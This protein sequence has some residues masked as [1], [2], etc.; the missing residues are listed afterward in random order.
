MT[1]LLQKRQTAPSTQAHASASHPAFGLGFRPFFLSA[2]VFATL[3]IPVWLLVLAGT[4]RLPTQLWPSAWHAHEMV[5][6]FCVAVVAG[7][8]LTA[9]GNWTQQAVPTGASL[10]SMWLLWLAGRALVLFDGPVPRGLVAIVDLAFVPTLALAVGLPIV[11]SKN[12]RNLAFVPLLL[13][14]FVANAAFHF[15]SPMVAGR[16]IQFAIDVIVLI[17]IAIGGR[18]IPMFTAN[19]LRLPARDDRGVGTAG[20]FATAVVAL[21]QL[22]SGAERIAGV[23]AIVAGA[24]H[25]VRLSRWRTT[26]TRGLPIVWVLHA[27]YAWIAIGL[28]LQGLA[29][30]FPSWPRSAPTHALTVG[31]L[32]TLI[33]GMMSRVSLGHTGRM[34]A[35]ARPV[36]AAY[37]LL[38]LAALVRAVG[39][40]VLPRAYALEVNVAGALWTA[41]FALFTW[42][43]WQILTTPRVDGRPG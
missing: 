38:S 18:V 35:V 33:L 40:I 43:Y 5:F 30:Y 4:L 21:L 17:A 15:G 9:V 34:L 23:V 29:V 12:W 32:S 10:A 25:A 14:L 7:F 13:L 20:F 2:G 41:A 3:A 37:V 39:P 24:L 11:R 6:G 27:G 16:A 19:A 1:N 26:A 28:V 36:V 31:A 8:L 22:F 42:R